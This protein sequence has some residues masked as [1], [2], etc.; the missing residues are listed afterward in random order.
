[1]RWI[2]I[3]LVIAACGGDEG[4]SGPEGPPGPAGERG[5]QG[6]QGPPGP[7]GPP[8]QVTV[9]DGGVVQGP[10]GP[11]GP[12]GPAGPAGAQGPIGPMGPIGWLQVASEQGG[13]LQRAAALSLAMGEPQVVELA[14]EADDP[15]R[16]DPLQDYETPAP[17][18]PDLDS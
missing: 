8:G 14:L 5:P 12:A 4:S 6:E 10:P 17:D 11:Q 3:A 1:M 7:Q 16:L 18:L 9:L 2:A 13:S 15:Q